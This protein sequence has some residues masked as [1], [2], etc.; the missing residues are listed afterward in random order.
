M[1]NALSLFPSD[2]AVTLMPAVLP[3]A[4]DMADGYF[5]TPLWLAEAIVE[6]YFPHLDS[7]SSV[8]EPFAGDG[9]FLRAIPSHVPAIGIEIDEARAEIARQTTGRR[10]ITGDATQVTLDMKVTDVISNPPFRVGIFEK[11]LDRVF[12]LLPEGARVGMI[13]PCSFFQSSS[14]VMRLAQTWSMQSELI[15]RDLFNRLSLPLAFALLSKNRQRTMVGF[16]FYRAQRE[17]KALP[18]ATQA[19]LQDTPKGSVWRAVVE[20]ALRQLGGA[21]TLQDI[22]A[23]VEGNRPT[24]N[25][26]WRE[27]VRQT[28]RRDFLCTAKGAYAL[29]QA[30]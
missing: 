29:A 28:C 13:V 2:V 24:T 30:A 3:T 16:A 25:Q 11:V 1:S 15:P 21:A 26:W 20:K 9:R 27:K 5:P 14:T 23:V 7:N 10:V 4:Q 19:L 18:Q 8:L 17:V 22:Y 12:P 6:K